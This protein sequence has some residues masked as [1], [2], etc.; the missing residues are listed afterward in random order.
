VD[1]N[2]ASAMAQTQVIQATEAPKH[3]MKAARFRS[4]KK[5]PH[6]A[7]FR[8][9]FHDKLV[10]QQALNFPLLHQSLWAHGVIGLKRLVNPRVG[11]QI[12]DRIIGLK[13]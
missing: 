4:Q 2:N 3:N 12:V 10:K 1:I 6:K 13:A 8:S 5:T 7:A 9:Y 11:G